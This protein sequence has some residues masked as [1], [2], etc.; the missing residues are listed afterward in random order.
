MFRSDTRRNIAD[1]SNNLKMYIG[2]KIQTN[3]K[4]Q[5]LTQAQL[6]DRVGKSVET[7]SNIE[8]GAVWT[9]LEMLEALTTTLNCPLESLFSGYQGQ[10]GQGPKTTRLLSEI[11]SLANE[12][13]VANLRVLRDLAQSLGRSEHE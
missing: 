2:S 10:I 7:I 8:R 11:H 5:R 12:L 9:S 13:S 6:A 1:M 3:R 4:K